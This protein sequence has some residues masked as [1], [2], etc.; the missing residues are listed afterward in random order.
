MYQVNSTYLTNGSYL[1]I[2]EIDRIMYC[3]KFEV[4]H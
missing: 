4:I 2:V 1:A 3:R